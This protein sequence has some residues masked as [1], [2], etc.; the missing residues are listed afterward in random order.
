MTKQ[1]MNNL[2]NE[3]QNT[4][5]KL[6]EFPL[7]SEEYAQKIKESRKIENELNLET[8]RVN[9]QI[10][11][12]KDQLVKIDQGIF[13]TAQ[14]E[15]MTKQGF[16]TYAFQDVFEFKDTELNQEKEKNL[17]LLKY[18]ILVDADEKDLFPC[19]GHYRVPLNEFVADD[20]IDP[21]PFGLSLKKKYQ[22][23]A[24]EES[25]FLA[26]ANQR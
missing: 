18:T 24:C 16:E 12:L 19:S 23:C 10:I 11:E 21:L 15:S 3:Q 17:S 6:A 1:S 2:Y 9:Q 25:S 22:P 14:R 26:A 8:E 13:D 20:S 5:A 7:R 4:Q